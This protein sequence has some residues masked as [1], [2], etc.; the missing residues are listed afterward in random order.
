MAESASVTSGT[1][2]GRRV[3][4]GLRAGVIIAL[5]VVLA[6]GAVV[7]WRVLDA[8]RRARGHLAEAER[9]LAE[10]NVEVIAVDAVVRSDVSTTSPEA[11]GQARERADRSR[12][13]LAEATGEVHRARAGLRT[14]VDRARADAIEAAITAREALLDQALP[15]LEIARRVRASLDSAD[16]AWSEIIAAES[17][18]DT[19][20][21]QFNKHTKAGVEASTKLTTQASG[22]LERAR[23]LLSTVAAAVPEAELQPFIAY[24]EARLG[25]LE[26][27]RRIDATWLAGR[28]EEANALLAAYN[29]EEKKLV[30]QAKGLPGTPHA[31]LASAYEAATKDA[32]AAYFDARESARQADAHLKAIGTIR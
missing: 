27:S 26:R 32:F 9:L 7:G 18:V 15:I 17:L 14:D 29:E 10:A 6:V 2:G 25:L 24:V 3:G 19:A 8:S 28:V 30:A 13:L 31:A 4:R 23:S 21:A 1:R 20:V 16:E 5:L 11:Y 22:K 12:A